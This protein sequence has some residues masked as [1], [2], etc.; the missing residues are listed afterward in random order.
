MSDYSDQT[1]RT[2]LQRRNHMDH[3]PQNGWGSIQYDARFDESWVHAG[4]AQQ[5]LFYCPWCGEKLPPSHRD[6]WFDELEAR[7]IDPLTDE[8]PER[9]RTGAWREQRSPAD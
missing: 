4:D 5:S 7:G 6:R 3:H 1:N 2:M 8:V 9:F